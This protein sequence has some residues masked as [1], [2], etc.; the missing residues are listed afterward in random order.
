[1]SKRGSLR[2]SDSDRDQVIDRLH[3]AATEGRIGSDELEQR[4]STALKA[5]TYDQLEATVADL[6]GPGRR[7][8]RG[9]EVS[10][11]SAPSWALST[12]RANPMLLL[13]V[14]PLLAVTAAMVLAAAVVWSVIMLVMF[15][16]GGRG[17]LSRP[18]WAH[19]ARR[20]VRSS[21]RYWA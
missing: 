3:K 17:M 21:G 7:R 18:P 15:M 1:M 5:L 11:R 6:P 16:F 14:I 19:A 13:F 20:G 8:D 9:G 2:A 12:V 10:R 4:V